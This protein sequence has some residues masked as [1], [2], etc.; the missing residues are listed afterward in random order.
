MKLI[1]LWR[2][3]VA[4]KERQRENNFQ[5]IYD[6]SSIHDFDQ[7]LDAR[8]TMVGFN[9]YL[10]TVK[11]Q[12]CGQSLRLQVIP[13]T[14]T[15]GIGKTTL[16]RNTFDDTLVVYHFD[17]RAW[18]TVSHDYNANKVLYTLLKSMGLQVDESSREEV[19]KERVYQHLKGM[20]YLIMMDDIWSIEVWDDLR[21]IFPDDCNGS[22]IVLTTRSLDIA[23]YAGG[24]GSAHHQI[25]FL[26]QE[27]NWKLF[28]EKVFAQNHCP[29]ELENI[30]KSIVS[31]CYGLPLAIVIIAGILSNV[32]LT[33]NDWEDVEMNMS[34][35]LSRTDEHI[36]RVVSLSYNHLP[37]Q[38]KACLL[39]MG[40]FPEDHE[41]RVS[42]LIR[43]WVAEGFLKSSNKSKSLEKVGEECLEHLVRRNLVIICKKGCSGQFE[44]CVLHDLGRLK[45]HAAQSPSQ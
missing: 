21:H 39:Y 8:N 2:S 15:G 16:A 11:D 14:G 13:F 28:Q 23:E 24:C 42:D 7:T 5:V 6:S 35:V 38:L 3:L 27:G 19:L 37:H 9:E 10:I 25:Q 31:K 33:L 34:T 45:M 44:S 22:R 12:P 30:G 41:L 40:S 4:I 26:N 29:S 43:L 20:R 1:Q 36:S 32:G 17:C 18:V